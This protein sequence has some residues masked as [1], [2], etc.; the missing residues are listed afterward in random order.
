MLAVELVPTAADDAFYKANERGFHEQLWSGALL[1]TLTR[2]YA[3]KGR[4]LTET[5]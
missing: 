5:I 4:R 1:N 2:I 3:N